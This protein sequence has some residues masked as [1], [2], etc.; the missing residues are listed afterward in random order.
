MEQKFLGMLRR[1]Q[2]LSL[3]L[4]EGMDLTSGKKAIST[5]LFLLFI[6]P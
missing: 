4:F 1:D 2:A 6:Q 5:L 3:T